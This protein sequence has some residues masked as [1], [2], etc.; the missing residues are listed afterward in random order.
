MEGYPLLG[1]LVMP[2]EV[3]VAENPEVSINNK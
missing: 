2:I 1:I 3:R